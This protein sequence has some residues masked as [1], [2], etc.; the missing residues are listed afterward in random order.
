MIFWGA[1]FAPNQIYPKAW[2]R[3]V[4]VRYLAASC[5][6]A[7]DWRSD[8]ADWQRAVDEREGLLADP[9]AR[10][11]RAKVPPSRCHDP[12]L[13]DGP[14]IWAVGPSGAC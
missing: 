4:R 9:G 3:Q 8:I 10:T 12:N 6:G 14:R 1:V 5:I 2:Q 7:A 13:P 11:E